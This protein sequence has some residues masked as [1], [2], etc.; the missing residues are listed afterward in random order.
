MKRNEH[1]GKHS[2]TSGRTKNRIV[3]FV[4]F[5]SQYLKSEQADCYC[6]KNA[7]DKNQRQ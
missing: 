3:N 2:R 6:G 5:A 4:D 1:P 7:H